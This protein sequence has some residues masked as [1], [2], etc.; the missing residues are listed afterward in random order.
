MIKDVLITV[1]GEQNVQGDSD[2]VELTTCGRFGLRDGKYFL[3]YEEG[4][5]DGSGKV[6][7]KINI[8][9][10]DFVALLRTGD[11]ES[12]MEIVKGERK[13]CLYATTVGHIYIDIYGEKISVDLNE[14]GG[15]IKLHY[16]IFSGLN[17][18]SRN[19]VEITV[20]EV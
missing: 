11:I 6:K 13:P 8:N 14:N 1:K 10:P 19:K 16:S 12:R 7:T 5:I 18:I 4:Q 20:K 9:S 2:S 3:S 17:V 15:K